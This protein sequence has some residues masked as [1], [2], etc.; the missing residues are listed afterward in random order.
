MAAA[1]LALASQP[2]FQDT[3]YGRIERLW[4]D[5]WYEDHLALEAA[6]T[7]EQK[8]TK[9]AAEEAVRLKWAE[10]AEAARRAEYAK[11]AKQL[12]T[13][14]EGRQYYLKKVGLPCKN[15]YYD[16]S[17]GTANAP[18]RAALTGSQCWAWER[19]EGGVL[20]KP[21]TCSH[22]HPGEDGW[23]PQWNHD[24]S[25]RISAADVGLA[26]W[27]AQRGAG[28]GGA[29]AAAPRPAPKP[30]AKPYVDNSAW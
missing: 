12:N 17:K 10:E 2:F 9:A 5:V 29:A 4:G 6:M 8:A 1:V 21:H 7:P 18:L 27:G 24:R 13:V 23:L 20:V 14:R 28:G 25:F 19:M 15:L 22:L 26:A 3:P 11:F 30:K 16:E